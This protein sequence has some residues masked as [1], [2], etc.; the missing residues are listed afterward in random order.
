MPGFK[1]TIAKPVYRQIEDHLRNQIMSGRLP[2]DARLP[3]ENAL[4]KEYGVSPLT[5]RR[6]LG[7]LVLDGLLRRKQRNGTFVT[8]IGDLKTPG[9]HRV[10][11]I[12]P[13][14]QWSFYQ[15]EYYREIIHGAG[16]VLVKHGCDLLL[17]SKRNESFMALIRKNPDVDGVII[18]GLRRCQLAD[19][20]EAGKS[21]IPLVVA[22]PNAEGTRIVSV[23][24][25]KEE[26][27]RLAIGYLA[28]KGCKQI[29]L[30][31]MHD[32]VSVDDGPPQFQRYYL[33]S[34]MERR[35]RGCRQALREQGLPYDRGRYLELLPG[36]PA[37]NQR[38]LEALLRS[39][40][41][42]G[43]VMLVSSAEAQACIQP[44]RA[45]FQKDIP[46][47]G[48]D[49]WRKIFSEANIPYVKNPVEEI[50]Q[51]AALSLIELMQRQG[52]RPPNKVVPVELIGA[53]IQP[54]DPQPGN[55][56]FVLNE[57]TGRSNCPL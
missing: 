34:L 5:M 7:C 45:H 48:F 3:P 14:E 54:P 40:R 33:G 12:A 51:A 47:V 31:G 16:P 18:M 49:N 39:K 13:I 50:G 41:A 56:R 37:D 8:N 29:A 28:G 10:M 53:G 17:T 43:V 30:I 2:A 35:L 55:K 44:M 20:V 1:P 52:K 19:L 57:T 46:L 9:R 38:R 23:D 4:A 22:G 11:V 26:G 36:Q 6:A 32:G 25:D 15:I 24:S 27:G 21:G 42:D